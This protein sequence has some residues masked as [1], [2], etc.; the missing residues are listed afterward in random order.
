MT[1]LVSV[2][3]ALRQ[4]LAELDRSA[5]VVD[6]VSTPEVEHLLQPVRPLVRSTAD[7]VY[8]FLLAL[9]STPAYKTAHAAPVP[10]GT[11]RR[12]N[13]ANGRSY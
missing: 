13:G 12:A 9:E 11:E 1:D 4:L 7:A 5:Y 8:R 6:G 3:T 2:N 10:Q